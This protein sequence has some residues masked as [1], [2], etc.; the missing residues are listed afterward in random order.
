MTMAGLGF[1]EIDVEFLSY[2]FI[3][4]LFIPLICQIKSWL[5]YTAQDIS[6]EE[7]NMIDIL[8]GYNNLFGNMQRK[9]VTNENFYSSH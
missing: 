4:L 5:F 2:L 6:C 7:H 1:K 8:K 9:G 3:P